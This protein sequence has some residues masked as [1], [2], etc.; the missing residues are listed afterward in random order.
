MM[1]TMDTCSA[2]RGS[3][4]RDEMIMLK[5]T[6]DKAISGPMTKIAINQRPSRKL[7]MIVG[8]DM[9]IQLPKMK[10]LN[11]IQVAASLRVSKMGNMAGGF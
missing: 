8:L 1:M 10:I 2:T 5:E 9:M 3:L 4:T 7:A 6:A 11:P